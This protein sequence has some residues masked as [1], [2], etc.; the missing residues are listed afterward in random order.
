MIVSHGCLSY[1]YSAGQGNYMY[2]QAIDGAY[3]DVAMLSKEYTAL[4]CMSFW[5][6]MN[7]HSPGTLQV[8]IVSIKEAEFLAS[9]QLPPS[10]S[11]GPHRKVFP[12]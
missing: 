9:M 11:F 2:Y 8:K 4:Q 10:G 1:Y 5:Y 3:D 6:Y 7:G 12:K